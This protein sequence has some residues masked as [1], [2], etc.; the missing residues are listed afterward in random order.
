MSIDANPNELKKVARYEP[1]KQET[2][3]MISRVIGP[4]ASMTAGLPEADI[5]RGAGVIDYHT[6]CVWTK[7]GHRI[8]FEML[9]GGG[10]LTSKSKF[11]DANAP[12]PN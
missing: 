9:V 10:M 4:V 6:K 11:P 2:L 5:R 3:E 12:D 8:T 7:D 1:L